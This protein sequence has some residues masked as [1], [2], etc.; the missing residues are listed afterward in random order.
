MRY[1]DTE[2]ADAPAKQYPD[3][4]SPPQFLLVTLLLSHAI[5]LAV[6]GDSPL[7]ASPTR[8]AAIISDDTNL[9]ALRVL[10]FAVYPLTM[11]LRM[12]RVRQAPLDRET[13]KL[14]F[15]AQCYAAAPLALMM[16]IGGTL[17]G[18]TLDA[19]KIAGIMLIVIAVIWF[20]SLE[21]AWF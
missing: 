20:L 11:A 13:L 21:P 4:L 15:F 14:P 19:L 7:V 5:E 2:L 1:A 9:I 3:V 17:L 6:V 18:C 16:S 12:V 8:L 10:A